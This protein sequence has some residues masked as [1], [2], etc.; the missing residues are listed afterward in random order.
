[1]DNSSVMLE[2]MLETPPS[3]PGGVTY[4]WLLPNQKGLDRFL[5]TCEAFSRSASSSYSNPSRMRPVGADQG[6]ALNTSAQDPNEMPSATSAA[7]AMSSYPTPPPSPA[8]SNNQGRALNT[9]S[10]GSNA[11]PFSPPGSASSQNP[12][13]LSFPS[14]TSHEISLFC[15]ATESFSQRNTNCSIAESLAR[16]HPIIAHAKARGVKARAYISV[17]LGC[18][19]DGPSAPAPGAV[20]DIAASLLEMGADAISVADTTGM[21]TPPRTRELLRALSA[22][23]IRREDVALH[24]HDTYGMALVNTLV[25]LEHGIRTFDAAV[26]G[27]GGCPFS[28]G[29]TGNVATEEMVYFLDS[30]GLRTGVDLMEVSRIG[31]W[32]NGELSRDHGIG[33]RVGKASLSRARWTEK[34]GKQ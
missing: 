17:A 4:Q 3:A 15:A 16:F 12:S 23:G 21:G 32:I 20:T 27:L 34:Q 9:S 8:P 30:L 6:P 13:S 24:F 18:P 7:D 11:M 19:F 25:A 26:G 33:S 31:E 28:P 29:A 14:S 22:A 1:M 5:S 2:H 10:R